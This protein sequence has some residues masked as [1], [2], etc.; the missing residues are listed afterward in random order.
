MSNPVVVVGHGPHNVIALHGWFGS[1][2]SWGPW[3]DALDTDAFTYAF[4]DYRG[5]G[6]RKDVPGTYNLEE[7]A[8]DVLSVADKLGW[9][10]FSLLGHSMGGAAIQ[11]VL[12]AHPERVRA[13]VGISPVPASGVPFDEATLRFFESAAEDAQ[14]RRTIHD[15]GTGSRLSGRWLDRMVENSMERSTPAAVAAYLHSWVKTDISSRVQGME[16]PVHVIVGEFDGAINEAF[17]RKTWLTCYPNASVEVMQ[18]AGHY[19]MD[20]TPAALAASVER[21]LRSVPLSD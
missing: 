8:E 19:A 11:H 1:A 3:V 9:K 18:N 6:A 7:I 15:R 20:E 2:K 21:F 16:L 13:L 10:R 5:Y 4:V 12:A 17:V 14:V